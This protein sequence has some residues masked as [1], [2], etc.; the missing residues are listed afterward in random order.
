MNGGAFGENFPYSNFHDLNL[1][2]VI[3]IAK[4]FLDQYT[5]I[6]ETITN[7]E[8]TLIETAT[9]LTNQLQEWYD[10]HSSDIS[11]ELASAI[12]NL[13]AELTSAINNFNYE[14][15]LK[16]S[17][18][19]ASIPSDYTELANSVTRVNTTLSQM[20]EPSDQILFTTGIIN[21]GEVGDTITPTVTSN[22]SYSHALIPVFSGD[23]VTIIAGRGGSGARLYCVTDTSYRVLNV[24]EEGTTKY[25][26][27]LPIEQDGYVILN[28]NNTTPPPSATIRRMTSITKETDK[29]LEY[30]N[31]KLMQTTPANMN[32]LEPLFLYGRTIASNADYGTAI[33][34]EPQINASFTALIIPCSVFDQFIIKGSGGANALLWAFTDSNYR[35]I[36]KS[37]ESASETHKIITAPDNGYFIFN[38]AITATPEAYHVCV[39]NNEKYYQNKSYQYE[40]NIIIETNFPVGTEITLTKVT[41][42]EGASCIFPVTIGDKI[43]HVCRGFTSYLAWCFIDTDNKIVA[44]SDE[45]IS[46]DTLLTAPCTGKFIANV[47]KVQGWYTAICRT[48]NSADILNAMNGGM[49]YQFLAPNIPDSYNPTPGSFEAISNLINVNTPTVREVYALYNNLLAEYPDYISREELPLMDQSET[50][51]MYCYTFRPETIPFNEG[52][53]PRWNM[54]TLPIIIMGGGVHGEGI[55]GDDPAMV[56]TTYFFI[57]DLC[58]N[59][60]NNEALKYLRWNVVI[61]LIPLQNPWGF[62]NR[63][64][65]N[66]RGVDINRNMPFGWI[67][68]SNTDSPSYAGTDPLSENESKNVKYI[69]DNNK[70]ALMYMDI[71]ARVGTVAPDRMMYFV[72]MDYSPFINVY[73]SIIPYI[74]AEWYKM[75]NSIGLLN[76]FVQAFNGGEGQLCNYA[77][78][79]GIAGTV[80][81]GFSHY[82]TTDEP[83]YGTVIT[84]ML[85]KYLGTFIMHSLKFFHDNYYPDNSRLIL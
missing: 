3:K 27:D 29:V 13:Q 44:K 48:V 54:Q 1:D 71:H 40:N 12:R 66:S 79:I 20:L 17:E 23:N 80:I 46:V 37:E 61:K 60:R 85:L 55:S 83:R 77:N 50:F 24:S 59:W 4:D 45:N 57:R 32:N 43:Y 30:I 36:E 34:P 52:N 62:E 5:H 58:E 74:S 84:E 8:T 53:E 78:S 82:S 67:Y 41:N 76:G 15:N 42:N 21:T 69:L 9:N 68:N 39:M 16:A 51:D 65:K 22:A 28:V 25:N 70:N 72:T 73:R 18:A 26:Y 14:A 6:Q 10:T 35:I 7:G 81:E 33:N 47:R 38:S 56:G 19:I 31:N 64:R 11:D 75:D 63:S 2:W 49:K